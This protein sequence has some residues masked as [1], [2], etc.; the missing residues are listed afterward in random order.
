[1]LSPNLSSNW[2]I[3]VSVGGF[4]HFVSEVMPVFVSFYQ[5]PE[6]LQVSR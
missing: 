4:C 1:M 5:F 6:T 2:A 3:S